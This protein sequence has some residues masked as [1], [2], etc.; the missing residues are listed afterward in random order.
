MSKY[1]LLIFLVCS[2]LNSFAQNSNPSPILKENYKPKAQFYFN[3]KPTLYGKLESTSVGKNHLN[4]KN[5][6]GLNIGTGIFV[7]IYNSLG[8]A[9]GGELKAISFNYNFDITEQINHPDYNE[10]TNLSLSTYQ[11]I[12]SVNYYF[13]LVKKFNRILKNRYIPV[14]SFGIK[15]NTIP[16]LG[17]GVSYSILSKDETESIKI[18]N[19]QISSDVGNKEIYVN[20]FS[21]PFKLGLEKV[22][23][24]LNSYQLNLVFNY[25]PKN[26]ARGTYSFSNIENESSG[27]TRLNASYIGIEFTYGISIKK[28]KS[29]KKPN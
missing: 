18:F 13:L 22:S 26:I 7:N 17:Y 16:N 28:P 14:I 6:K 10:K 9:F 4:P 2:L 21:Y 20:F 12:P 1:F 25:S 15:K 19:S 29:I 11:Y 23:N 3:I 24:K 8:I 5:G 27:T